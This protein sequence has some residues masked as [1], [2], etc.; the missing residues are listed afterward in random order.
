M[1]RP[2]ICAP[3]AVFD[4][5]RHPSYAGKKY[6]ACKP[7][8]KRYLG[9]CNVFRYKKSSGPAR[10]YRGSNGRFHTLGWS[11]SEN[12]TSKKFRCFLSFLSQKHS[13]YLSIHTQTT[14]TS[15]QTVTEVQMCDHAGTK[16]SPEQ[17]RRRVWRPWTGNLLRDPGAQQLHGTRPESTGT[18]RA[19]D[20]RKDTSNFDVWTSWGCGAFGCPRPWRAAQT[21]PHTVSAVSAG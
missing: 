5:Y 3:D 20:G 19:Q 8:E 15:H 9:N 16:H 1:V 6:K 17:T 12:V 4:V 10:A 2:F 7:V 11:H 21:A 18:A 13:A 14:H